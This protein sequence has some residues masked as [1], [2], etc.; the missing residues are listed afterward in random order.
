MVV[1]AVA[2]WPGVQD[3]ISCSYT[4]SHGISPGVAVLVIPW[5]PPATIAN[6]GI[7]RIQDGVNTPVVLKDCKVDSVKV[8]SLVDGARGLSIAILDRRWRWKYGGVDGWYN[9]QDPD[10][11]ISGLPPG[12]YV[13]P[14]SIYI[15]GT[16]RTPLQLML[17]C[18]AAMRETQFLIGYV[19]TEPRPPIDWAAANPAAALQQV[20]DAVGCRVVFQ[21]NLDR[22][23]IQPTGTGVYIESKLRPILSDSPG[24]EPDEPP[25]ACQIASGPLWIAD[26]LPLEPVGLEDDGRV[27]PIDELSYKPD[28]GWGA[29]SPGT[30]S[31]FVKIGDSRDKDTSRL[32]ASKYVWRAFRVKIPAEGLDLPIVGKVFTRKQLV[33]GSRVLLATK[34]ISGQYQAQEPF[35]T[36]KCVKPQTENKRLA[37]YDWPDTIPIPFSID[38]TRG[39]VLFNRPV[40]SVDGKTPIPDT[41]A[42]NIHLYTSFQVRRVGF[43]QLAMLYW[44]REF[45]VDR[46][47]PPETIYRSEMT[48]VYRV[49]REIR[50]GNGNGS[51]NLA[52]VQT[53]YAE[54]AAQANFYLD[55]AYSKYFIGKTHQVTFGGIFPDNPTGLIQQVSWSCGV[56]TPA[57]TTISVGMEHSDYMPTYPERRRKEKIERT[58]SGLGQLT[59]DERQSSRWHPP[60]GLIGGS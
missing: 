40:Y 53:N 41:I 60:E 17:D 22:V 1:H 54:L 32:L 24:W 58:F 5:Q 52:E 38:A 16:E 21:P 55:A 25:G 14:G 26:Y 19:P 3:Y 59:R 49:V 51:L 31:V 12:E 30:A 33:L 37:E 20:C 56:G 35:I 4:C 2:L 36:G 34:D 57:T 39:L 23:L 6:F 27:V 11:D 7:L 47:A 48:P 29:Y 8:V 13:F 44:G 28:K 15:P 18:L 10:P 46:G 45:W 9:Q 42:P 50:S 43:N